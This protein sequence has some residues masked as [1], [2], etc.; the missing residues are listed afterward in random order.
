MRANN[1]KDQPG[2]PG[3]IR[4]RLVTA[5]KKYRGREVAIRVYWALGAM[6]SEPGYKAVPIGGRY[7]YWWDESVSGIHKVA[8]AYHKADDGKVDRDEWPV[9]KIYPCVF[10]D[11]GDGEEEPWEN[12]LRVLRTNWHN[13]KGSTGKVYKKPIL[14][15]FEIKRLK[16]PAHVQALISA[17][18]DLEQTLEVFRT[19]N[20]AIDLDSLAGGALLDLAS[21]GS[22]G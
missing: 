19:T 20:E 15:A 13:H 11:D 18:D 8:Y 16:A 14:A 22:W 5:P 3:L 21:I 6:E 17:Q 12:R 4:V 9:G 10:L 7:R 1:T 2:L